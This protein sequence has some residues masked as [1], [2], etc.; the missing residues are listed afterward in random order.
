V[1]APDQA[2]HSTSMMRGMTPNAALHSMAAVAAGLAFASALLTA[3]WTLG[4]TAL[5]DTVGGYAE[6]FA[7]TGGTL[8]VLVGLLVVA[9]KVVG[10]L[11]ALGLAGRGP[12]RKLHRPLLLAGGLGSGLLIIYGGLLVAVGA[13]VLTGVL[14]PDDPIDRRALTWHVLLWD[15]WFLLWGLTLAATTWQSS[16]S[17]RLIAQK[18]GVA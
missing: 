6:E 9:V 11:V 3:Y 14:Q 7:R 17:L 15:L 1:S 16:R 2:A 10:G 18:Q 12:G 4:G 8:A 13:L 5:L